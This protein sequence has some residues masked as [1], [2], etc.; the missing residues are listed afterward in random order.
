MRVWKNMFKFRLSSTL[1]L[2]ISSVVAV[3]APAGAATGSFTNAPFFFDGA[4]GGK[5]VLPQTIVAGD[6]REIGANQWPTYDTATVA[7]TPTATPLGEP[8]Y[9]VTWTAALYTVSSWSGDV[10]HGTWNFKTASGALVFSQQ[11][12]FPG[13]WPNNGYTTYDQAITHITQAQFNSI[14]SVDWLGD[15]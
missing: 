15:C 1:V 2:A 11:F 10:W 5:T 7:L 8:V 12:D 14:A 9:Q 3:S 6:C 4:G 13:M